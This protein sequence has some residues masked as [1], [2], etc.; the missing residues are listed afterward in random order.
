MMMTTIA[1][2]VTSAWPAGPLLV[3][4][5]ATLCLCTGPTDPTSDG[6]HYQGLS[7]NNHL[8]DHHDHNDHHHHNHHHHHCLF[9]DLT[10]STYRAQTMP[11]TKA[12]V[13]TTRTITIIIMTITIITI[14]I[15]I[16][17]IKFI[18]ITFVVQTQPETAPSNKEDLFEQMPQSELRTK[19]T[20]RLICKSWKVKI[21]KTFQCSHTLQKMRR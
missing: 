2:V 17:I 3:V 9:T 18:I 15:T 7:A 4:S 14:T 19:V 12:L 8:G 20:L 13:P 5:E 6:A 1:T 11:T 10:G 16:I 21:F